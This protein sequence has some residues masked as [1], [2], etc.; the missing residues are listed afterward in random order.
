[1]RHLLARVSAM[2][3]LIGV[4]ATAARANISTGV[5]APN[6]TKSQLAGGPGTWSKGAAVSLSGYAGKVVVLFLLGYS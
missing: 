6:F 3:A 4:L 2:A 5:P 1:M